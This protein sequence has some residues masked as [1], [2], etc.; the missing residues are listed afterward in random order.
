[1]NMLY[2]MNEQTVNCS[3][4]CLHYCSPCTVI[5]ACVYYSLTRDSY[6]HV[7]VLVRSFRHFIHVLICSTELRELR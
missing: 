3:A 2:V 6:L 1:M 5:T 7:S 4:Q